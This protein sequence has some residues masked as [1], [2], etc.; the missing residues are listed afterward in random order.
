MAPARERLGLDLKKVGEIAA[1]EQLKDEVQVLAAVIAEVKVFVKRLDARAAQKEAYRSGSNDTVLR[2]DQRIH[3]VGLRSVKGNGA[4]IQEG[5]GLAIDV[6]L[7]AAEVARVARIES[8]VGSMGDGPVEFRDQEGV[9]VID[10][11][12]GRPNGDFQSHDE[13]Q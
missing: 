8:L 5:P 3:Q 10:G 9:A 12:N 7:I 13:F 1:N 2:D 6:Q 4:G 11:E